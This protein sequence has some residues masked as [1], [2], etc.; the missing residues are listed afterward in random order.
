ML[1][2]DLLLVGFLVQK[3]GHSYMRAEKVFKDGVDV[4]IERLRLDRWLL[5]GRRV[6]EIAILDMVIA[7]QSRLLQ[8]VRGT[9]CCFRR[10]L[11]RP[12]KIC[13]V[14]GEE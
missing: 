4:G 10:I 9:R 13:V 1:A 8:L 11:R 2:D 5:N 3:L 6:L 14:F 7:R 12:R